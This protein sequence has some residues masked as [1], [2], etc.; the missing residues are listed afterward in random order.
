MKV[1]IVGVGLAGL[2][3]TK[4]LR[5]HRTEVAVFEASDDS[6]LSGEQTAREVLG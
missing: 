1:I 3:R 5:E 4:M 6:T 2:A